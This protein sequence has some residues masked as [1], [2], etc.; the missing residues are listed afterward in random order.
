MLKQFTHG[1]TVSTT[2]PSGQIVIAPASPVPYYSVHAV[3]G[4]VTFLLPQKSLAM[5]FKYEDEYKA[6]SGPIG[7]TIV[8]GGTWTLKIPK[9]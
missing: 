6:Y 3:E 4:Q 8:F 2:L 5:F 9:G 1:G 7:N